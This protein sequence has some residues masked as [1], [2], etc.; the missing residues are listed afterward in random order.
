MRRGREGNRWEEKEEE[1]EEEEEVE[2]KVDEGGK[3]K[4]EGRRRNKLKVE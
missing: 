2:G 3:W 1:E 4:D